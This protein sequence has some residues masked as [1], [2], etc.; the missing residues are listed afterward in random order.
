M[1]VSDKKKLREEIKKEIEDLAKP[2][3]PLV[4]QGML[5][6]IPNR[7]GWYEVESLNVLPDFAGK[8]IREIE[9]R[10]NVVLVKI[11]SQKKAQKLLEKLND[12][13]SV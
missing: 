2:I 4:E 10:D 3:A 9:T 11:P 1:Y 8:Q 7:R 6:P 5:K 12:Q 13:G